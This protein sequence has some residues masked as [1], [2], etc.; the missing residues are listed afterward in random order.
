MWDNYLKLQQ[1][2][3]HDGLSSREIENKKRERLST[4]TSGMKNTRK[5]GNKIRKQKYGKSK[6]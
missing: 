3:G 5:F 2:V 6:W 4:G 1:E